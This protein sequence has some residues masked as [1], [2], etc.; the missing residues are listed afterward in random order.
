MRDE[1]YSTG[2]LLLL[3]CSS[4][5]LSSHAFNRPFNTVVVIAVVFRVNVLIV[6][7]A[8]L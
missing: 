1:E 5:K 3:L 7:P 2:L 8:I 6:G 4:T